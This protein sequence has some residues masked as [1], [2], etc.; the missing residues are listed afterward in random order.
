M[1]R[2]TMN[3]RLAPK[4]GEMSHE[5]TTRASDA[6]YTAPWPPYTRPN[7][8]MAPMMQCVVDTGHPK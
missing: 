7:P 2:Y 5:D 1:Q 3:A 6:Q 8:T 4:R